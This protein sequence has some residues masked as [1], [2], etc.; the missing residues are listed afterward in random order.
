MT[1]PFL[2]RY[3]SS[4]PVFLKTY[5]PANDMGY[6]LMQPDNSLEYLKV[7]KHLADIGEYI[8]E[9]NFDRSRLYPVTFGLRSNISY[10]CNYHSLWVKYVWSLDYSL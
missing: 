2:L 10:E 7:L 4:K 8:F 5:R 3:D 9:L 6:I 1:S